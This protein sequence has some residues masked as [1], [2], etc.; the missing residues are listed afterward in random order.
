M[1]MNFV[2]LIRAAQPAGQNPDRLGYVP[3]DPSLSQTGRHQAWRL[4]VHIASRRPAAIYSSPSLR[5]VLTAMA[6]APELWDRMHGAEGSG[7]ILARQLPGLKKTYVSF[8]R[9]I[10]HGNPRFYGLCEP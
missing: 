1:D 6:I 4:G 10:V 5:A 8:F 2:Y 9:A 3:A 7:A